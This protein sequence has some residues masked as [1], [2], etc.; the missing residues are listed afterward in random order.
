MDNSKTMTNT[1]K[2]PQRVYVSAEAVMDF[3]TDIRSECRRE[4]DDYFP[5]E[6]IRADLV[7][8]WVKCSERMPEYVYGNSNYYDVACQHNG[9][10]F[11]R[12]A[13]IGGDGNWYDA[14]GRTRKGIT[15]WRPRPEYP[16]EGV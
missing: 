7:P 16:T 8:Q 4:R 13:F 1:T 9:S 15:H 6:Y 3:A 11:I 14:N 10:K 2:M 5:H 12:C